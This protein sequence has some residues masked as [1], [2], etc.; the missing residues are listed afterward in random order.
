MT[1]KL[2]ALTIPG[3]GKVQ[4]PDNVPSNVPPGAIISLALNT[5]IF[6]GIILSLLYLIYGGIHWLQ[7]GGDKTKLD[8]SRRILVYA[9]VGLIVMLLSAV[10]VN[11]I[12]ASIGINNPFK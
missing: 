2:L 3:Y 11:V 9:V 10:I 12:L 7:S 4:T 6:V 8:K 5:A 1:D